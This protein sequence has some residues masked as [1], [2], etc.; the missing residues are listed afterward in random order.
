M[1]RRLDNIGAAPLFSLFFSFSAVCLL[2]HKKATHTPKRKKVSSQ[3]YCSVVSKFQTQE[4]DSVLYTFV[5][6]PGKLKGTY[7][8]EK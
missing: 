2:C 8:C 1:R 7:S 6:K 4:I 5:C 3:K